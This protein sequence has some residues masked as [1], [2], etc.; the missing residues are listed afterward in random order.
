MWLQNQLYGK[1]FCS[2]L[3]PPDVTLLLDPLSN[4]PLEKISRNKP[5]DLSQVV[6]NLLQPQNISSGCLNPKGTVVIYM[7][8]LVASPPAVTVASV[9]SQCCPGWRLACKDGPQAINLQQ[10]KHKKVP[11]ICQEVQGQAPRVPKARLR[12]ACLQYFCRGPRRKPGALLAAEHCPTACQGRSGPKR[13]V[14]KAKCKA[15]LT[16]LQV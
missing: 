5:K 6:L 14:R 15:Q 12:G 1:S 9:S 8:G 16:R 7:A 10:E 2:H 3:V 4:I 13:V 11:E